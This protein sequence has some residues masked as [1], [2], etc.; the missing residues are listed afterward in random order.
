MKCHWYCFASERK[1]ASAKC[2]VWCAN[3]LLLAIQ[4]LRR[5][6]M[7]Q[8]QP[9]IV[10]TLVLAHNQCIGSNHNYGYIQVMM[11]DDPGEGVLFF[12]T[13]SGITKRN[14]TYFF[15]CKR[16]SLYSSYSSTYSLVNE[17][18]WFVKVTAHSLAT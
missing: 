10:N 17:T 4:F 16:N 15:L 6:Y 9:L 3:L 18:A 14:M 12:V 5:G 7:K 1:V 11:R 13:F 2:L 8:V